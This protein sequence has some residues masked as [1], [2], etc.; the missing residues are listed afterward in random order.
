MLFLSLLYLIIIGNKYN[1]GDV[2]KGS[3]V[4][5]NIPVSFIGNSESSGLAVPSPVWF[6]G[7]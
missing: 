7:W 1:T 6:I 5:A 2:K 3:V 4:F